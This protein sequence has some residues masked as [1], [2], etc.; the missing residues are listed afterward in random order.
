MTTRFMRPRTPTLL[1]ALFTALCAGPLAARGPGQVDEALA[2]KTFDATWK[3][4]DGSPYGVRARGI[5]W[6]AIGKRHRSRVAGARDM[7]T[8]RLRLTEMLNEIGE[9]HFTIVPGSISEVVSA[10]AAAPGA[11]TA[12][13]KGLGMDAGVVEGRVAVLSV[14]PDTPAAR[15]GI[16]PGW[17]IE[18]IDDTPIDGVLADI[19]QLPD[20]ESRREAMLQLDLGL[21]GRF[22]PS[23]HAAPAKL[24]FR[25]AA[26][27]RVSHTLTPAATRG[28]VVNVPMLPPVV[29][30]IQHVRMSETDGGCVGLIRFNLWAP[31]LS[32]SFPGA[33]AATRECRGLILDLRGNPGGVIGTAMGVGGHLVQTATALGYLSAGGSNARLTALPRKVSDAGEPFTPYA[34]PLVVLVDGR[35]ASTSEVFASGLQAAGRAHVVGSRSAGKALP[36]LMHPLPN[37]DQL[38]YA[39]ADLTAPDGGRLEGVGIRP[40]TP[41]PHTLAALSA[42]Q[43]NAMTAARAWIA[44]QPLHP[45]KE[46][47]P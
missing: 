9:S 24:T 26:G 45:D 18:A 6:D 31:A 32:T 3:L 44:R 5:D 1:L 2:L 8:L 42:G 27:R 47:S 40:D 38:M 36:S 19:R 20:P 11:D 30:R 43:D 7:A 12:A 37:G 39:V 33:L 23:L 4:V 16:S 21:R 15:A 41:A 13:V 10:R 29:Y 34:G 22:A 35:S 28:E 17:V 25:D 46:A 14:E